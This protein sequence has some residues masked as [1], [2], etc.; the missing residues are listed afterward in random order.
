MFTRRENDEAKMNGES[1]RSPQARLLLLHDAFLMA[2]SVWRWK[3]STDTP[4]FPFGVCSGCFQALRL[5]ESGLEA[6]VSGRPR[7]KKSACIKVQLHSQRTNRRGCR[8]LT[9][10]GWSLVKVRRFGNVV[11]NHIFF[12]LLDICNHAVISS[13]FGETVR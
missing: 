13:D 8:Q 1:K 11:S 7:L 10:A 6:M 5:F 9:A 3:I 12:P 4:H 2:C